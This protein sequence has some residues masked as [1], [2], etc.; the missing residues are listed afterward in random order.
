MPYI[1]IL[2]YMGPAGGVVESNVSQYGRL[3]MFREKPSKF[4]GFP[5][6]YSKGYRKKTRSD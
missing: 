4:M 3:D 1:A 5:K 2:S 6:Y